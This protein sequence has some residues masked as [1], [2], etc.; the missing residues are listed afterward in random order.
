[1]HVSKE[2]CVSDHC[3]QYSLSDLRDRDFQVL[4]DRCDAM[5]EVL[6]DLKNSLAMMTE[7]NIGAH[8]KEE[9]SFIADQAISNL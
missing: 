2:L 6:L 8:A 9:L 4:C 5:T 7:Q 1:M 3:L